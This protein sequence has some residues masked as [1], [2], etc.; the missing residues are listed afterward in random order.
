MT[1]TIK[2]FLLD[3]S[4]AQFVEYGLLLALI[5][6]VAMTGVKVL[7]TNLNGLFSSVAASL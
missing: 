3:E 5:A 1:A 2:G 6:I 7:G 4:G